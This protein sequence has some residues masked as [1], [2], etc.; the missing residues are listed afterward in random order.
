MT[1]KKQRNTFVTSS[2]AADLL[3]VALSTVQL[4]ANKGLL[5]TWTTEGGHRRISK[6]SVQE[7]LDQRYAS[8]TTNRP[9]ASNQLTVVIVEDDSAQQRVYTQQ[10][11]IRALPI[12]LVIA[13]DGFDG[14]I[15]VGRLNPDVL[16]TDLNMPNM[17][18]FEM[19]RA[20]QDVPE[21]KSCTMIAVS[22]YDSQ[23][24]EQKGGLPESVQLYSKPIPFNILID[25]I[26]HKAQD[27]E[28]SQAEGLMVPLK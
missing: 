4:W 14:L 21:M 18:G 15:Q 20:I 2:Q 13:K 10:L 22:S 12:N 26:R 11:S 8:D 27:L 23:E 17:N 9:P 25:L 28:A 3:S 16:I 5:Q 7:M 1:M 24:I 19:I 6:Q